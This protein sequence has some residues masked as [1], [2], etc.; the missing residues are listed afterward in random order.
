VA[1]LVCTV[2]LYWDRSTS[3]P[4]DAPATTAL[5]TRVV[6]A[7]LWRSGSQIVAQMVVWSATFVVIRLLNPGDYGLFAMS[8]VVLILLSLLNG[9][10]FAD[11]LVR[12]ERVG[13]RDVA[14]VFGI[15]VLLNG[16]IALAQVLLAPLIA[17]YYDEPIIAQL[18]RVQALLYL[19]NPFILVPA[20]LLSRAMDF[21]RQA[22]V[23]LLSALAGALASVA[24]AVAGFAVWTLVA[25]PLAM[26]WTRAIG[27]TLASPMRVRPSF[28]LGGAGATIRFGGA[29]LLSTALWLV[30]TQ[31]DVIIAARSL[32]VHSLGLYTTSLFLA[33]IVTSKFV[34]PLNEVAFTAYA[35]LQGDRAEAAGAFEKSVRIVMLAT[36]PLFFGLAVTAE[37]L[38]ATMLGPKWVEIPPIVARLALAMPF[39]VLQIMFTPATSALGHPRIQVLS[40]AAGAVIMPVAFVFGVAEGARGLATAW[41]VAFP[42]LT[43]VTASLAMPIIGVGVGAL[44]RAIAPALF[45]AL[46][47]ALVVAAANTRLGEMPTPVRLATLI[48]IGGLVY[49]GLIMVV[50]RQTVLSIWGLFARRPALP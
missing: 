12:A 46:G 5:G 28:D 1:R 8:Q 18:L 19:A 24:C 29:M 33:Q 34:P 23:N 43:V 42:L 2:L 17:D 41:L 14:Q 35:R 15:L 32:D 47:M 36:M 26:A 16:G 38:V 27:M 7:V 6:N 13:E 31:S 22:R 30:Q 9:S 50:A 25:A 4:S 40:A 21:R 37:P 49:A 39:V 10:G 45:C 3:M 11:A 20:A 44:T 48:A